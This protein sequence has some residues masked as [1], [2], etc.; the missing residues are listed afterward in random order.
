MPANRVKSQ[1]LN[2]F[3]SFDVFHTFGSHF[4]A[5]QREKAGRAKTLTVWIYNKFLID[6]TISSYMLSVERK[7]FTTKNIFGLIHRKQQHSAVFLPFCFKQ[8][9]VVVYLCVQTFNEV[10]GTSVRC[11]YRHCNNNDN[12]SRHLKCFL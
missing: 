10:K 11:N 9:S 1:Y 5:L 7:D 2:A 3:C 12:Y 8:P 6:E 4:H